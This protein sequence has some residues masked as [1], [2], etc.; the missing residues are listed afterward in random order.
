MAEEMMIH[1]GN[2]I[3][4]DYNIEDPAHYIKKNFINTLS[5]KASFNVELNEDS[6]LSYD[7][8]TLINKYSNKDYILDIRTTKW[9]LTYFKW[10]WNVYKIIYHAKLRL[11][12]TKNGNIIAKR[13][14]SSIPENIKTAPPYSEFLE[15]NAKILKSEL[16]LAANKCLNEFNKSINY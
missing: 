13:D 7:Y 11:I 6:E 5:T 14:C 10:D 12:N 3:I 1:E 9:K 8:A 16:Q 2:K 4:K 15:N